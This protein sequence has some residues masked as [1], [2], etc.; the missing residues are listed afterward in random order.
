MRRKRK[1]LLVV[2]IGLLAAV[3]GACGSEE[4]SADTPA[5]ESQDRP[6]DGNPDDFVPLSEALEENA[7]WFGTSATEPGSLTRDTSIGRVFVFHKGA[8]KYYDY[9]DPDDSTLVEEHLTIEDV[10]DM[11]D[12]E[13]KK[14]AKQNGEEVDLGD[15]SLDIALDDSGNM[16]EF[17]RLITDQRP[18][19]EKYPT[20]SSTIMPT[21]F[22]DT[23]FVAIGTSRLVKGGWPASGYLLTKVDKPTIFILDDADTKN[24]RVTVEEY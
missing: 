8:V 1:W 21:N 14:H 7:I 10:V 5:Q 20:F 19:D 4:T 9:R 23:D 15:Y 3:L 2:F 16:T 24:K 13:I 6:Q 17:E 18:E 11:S 22:F 12:K